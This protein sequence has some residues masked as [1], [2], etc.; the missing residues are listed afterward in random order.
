MKEDVNNTCLAKAG[1]GRW[2]QFHSPIVVH[3]YGKHVEESGLYGVDV[4]DPFAHTFTDCLLLIS[5]SSVLSLPQIWSIN[6]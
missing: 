3:F 4:G 6:T 1:T 2:L 5:F